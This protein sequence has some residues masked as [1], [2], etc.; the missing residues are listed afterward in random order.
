MRTVL[1]PIVAVAFL[2][3]VLPLSAQRSGATKDPTLNRGEGLEKSRSDLEK[4]R[5][6]NQDKKGKVVDLY[7]F[8]ASY[9]LLDSVMYVSD[10]QFVEGLTVFNR[11]FL[12]NRSD[13]EKQFNSF[14]AQEHYELYIPVI[15]FAESEKKLIRQREALIKR[16]KRKMGL[17]L[18]EVDDFQFSAI[19]SDY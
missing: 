16:N 2:L 1:K 4:M 8:A 19:A 5:N 15:Y 10:V 11:W 12:R 13:Y 14:A 7:M 9:S 18:V 3:F 17:Y 6:Q